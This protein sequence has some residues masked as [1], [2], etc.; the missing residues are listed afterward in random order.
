MISPC[1][2]KSLIVAIHLGFMQKPVIFLQQNKPLVWKTTLDRNG[3]KLYGKLS[4][5]F[6]RA[7]LLTQFV[8]DLFYSNLD[9][10]V[11]GE[12]FNKFESVH[13]VEC[14]AGFGNFP[15]LNRAP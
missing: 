7:G 14:P 15:I 8:S 2:K 6:R 11:T 4:G 5:Q 12:P 9:P 13:P 1:F 3:L 10:K